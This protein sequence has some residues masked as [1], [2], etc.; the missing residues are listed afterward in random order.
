MSR[1]E[2]LNHNKEYK[3]ML[4]DRCILDCKY[5]LGY[6]NRCKEQL[7]AKDE[8][9]QIETMKFIYNSFSDEEKPKW[10][11]MEDIEAL[12]KEM[13]QCQKKIP[14]CACANHE[15]CTLIK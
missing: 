13:L 11:S 14:C 4:L 7:W 8:R 1:E 2:I 6:G 15:E 3:Y 10:T 9:E 5:Y 12:E